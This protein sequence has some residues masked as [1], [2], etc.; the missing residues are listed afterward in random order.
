M[1]ISAPFIQRPVATSLMA[2]AVLLAGIVAFLFLPVA[3]L[4]RIDYPNINVWANLPGASPETMASAVATPLERRFA[5]IA[6]VTEITSSSSLGSTSITLQFELG[7]NVDRAARDVQAA[8]NAAAGELPANMP[9]RPGYWKVNPSDPAILV[10]SVKSETLP[11]RQVA[12]AADAVLAHKISQVPGVGQVF[13]GGDVQPAVRVQVDPAALAGMGLG[14]VDVRQA[15]AQATVDQPKGSLSGDQQVHALS[16][17]DQLFGA[18]QFES[19]VLAHRNGATVYLKD[20]ARVL[21]DVEDSRVAG[22]ANGKPAVLIFVRR[23]PGANIIDV[24]ARVRAMLP[25]LTDSLSPAI[26]VSV[27]ADRSQT[28]RASVHDVE[29]TWL[30]SV[31][32]V[33]LVVF[34]FL[35]NWRM[36]AIPTVAVPLSIVATFGVMYLLNYS[37]DNLSL[38][39]LTISTGFVVDDAIV[40]TENVTRYIEL[41]DSPMQA[42]LKGARQVGFTVVSIT[43]SL[44]AVFIPILLMGGIIGRLFREFAVTLSIA[45]AVSALVSLTLTPMM[46]SRLL[47]PHGEE[48]H[49]ALYQASEQFFERMLGG[50]ARGLRWVLGHHRLT[51]FITVATLGLTVA[52]YIFVPKGFFPQQDTGFISGFIEA[53]QD[54][55]FAVME[56]RQAEVDAIL[57]ADPDVAQSVSFVG[58]GGPV[59]TGS[60]YVAL[61]PLGERQASAEEVIARLRPK[62]ERIPGIAVYLQPNQ[63]V[64]VGGRWSRTQ[65]QYTLQDTNVAELR[66]WTPKVVDALKKLPQVR[67]VASDQQTA[68]LEMAFSI[69]RDTAA[70]LGVSPKDIDEALYDAYGQRQVAT[71]YTQV[72]QYRVVLEIKP[73]FLKNTDGLQS[74][75]VRAADG[76]QVP[77][78]SLVTQQV[79]PTSLAIPHQGQF[80]STT[81]SFALAPDVSL[82]QAV[83]AIHR[84]ELEI[85]L[86]PSVHADFQGTAQAY[87]SSLSSQ[88]YLIIAAIFIVYI[89]LGV[90]YESLVHPITILSTL[91]SAGLGALL[92]LMACKTELS[93]ISIIGIILLVGIVKKNAILMID[94]AI[95][96]ER[97]ENLS[98]RDAIYKASVLRFRP[99]MMTTMAALLGALPLALG[100]GMGSELRRPLGI[101]IVG[102]LAISQM[103][104]LFTVPV[105]YLYMDRFSRRKSHPVKAD[106]EREPISLALPS[107]AV[108][109]MQL[110]GD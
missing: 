55:S 100:H 75:Y 61:K 4:P 21:D 95:E 16:A 33:V 103:L 79:R 65:Y 62:F 34:A 44:I 56:Q 87:E 68:G 105:I 46:C 90:L 43:V 39:A 63:D 93:V 28:I 6:G 14:M 106:A 110:E 74:I 78:A 72:N 23:Q 9:W 50:Y 48:K 82:G 91:P 81:V 27:V 7:R 77:L 31:G 70:R 54:T 12:D 88:P 58:G 80:P 36:T 64:R 3:S 2:A 57:R 108:A 1:N 69:D 94:F 38:M 24:I 66:E 8:I 42:A 15:L 76:S 10:L 85:G 47:R 107:P 98:A 25:R 11:L 52:L 30:L 26:E 92:A 71:T 60:A 86:P 97:D 32:L 22:W 13:T 20:V 83:D 49:G 109:D 37:L 84:A 45:V 40:V 41:G 17:N 19:L 96:V 99:I 29:Q 73:E 104:T 51:L 89:V 101:A 5:R 67:D 18:K 102:G 59:N 53:A 35:R